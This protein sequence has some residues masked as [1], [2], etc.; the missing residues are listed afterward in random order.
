MLGVSK[1][2]HCCASSTNLFVIKL[3]FNCSKNIKGNFKENSKV[4]F[5]ILQAECCRGDRFSRFIVPSP[6]NISIQ[7]YI[8]TQIYKYTQL[9]KHSKNA[10]SESHSQAGLAKYSP[11]SLLQMI[12]IFYI[13]ALHWKLQ[14]KCS[15]QAYTHILKTNIWFRLA[16]RW[17]KQ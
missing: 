5:C 17:P 6:W 4:G 3:E 2:H 8:K 10:L 9:C 7:K 14:D 11:F 15:F 16:R 13:L 12:Q 1:N